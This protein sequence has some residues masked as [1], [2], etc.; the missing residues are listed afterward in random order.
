MSFDPNGN[1]EILHGPA[2][3]WELIGTQANP[4]DP[5]DNTGEIV[6]YEKK[7][8][9]VVNTGRAEVLAFISNIITGSASAQPFPW[10]CAG[11]CSTAATVTDTRLNYELRGN[12]TRVAIT[13]ISSTAVTRANFNTATNVIGGVTY[14]MNVVY[15]GVYGA[16]DGNNLQPFQE[17]ALNT[18]GVLPTTPTATS[19]VIFNHLIASAPLIKTDQIILT[20]N[21]TL[22]I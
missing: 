19:G 9:L 5:Y 14:Y 3:V 18:I 1:L 4:D 21:L 22:Y 11:A 15:Q 20:V 7:E 10:L 12:A 2:V 6:Y 8:N 13:N 16:N 17:Y